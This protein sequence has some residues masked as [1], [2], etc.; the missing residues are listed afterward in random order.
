MSRKLT[1]RS[2]PDSLKKEA[3]RW[4]KALQAGDAM[5]RRRLLAV[6]P[7]A[8][9]EPGLRDVQLALA[10]EYG[11]PG[12]AVV[13]QALKDARRSHAERVELVLR[14]ADWAGDH[15]GG[16]RLLTRW[17]EIGRDSLHAAAATGNVAEVA[18]RLAADPA[19]A[20]RK[21]GPLD[22][23]PLLYLAYSRLPGSETRSVEIARLLLDHGAD[24]NARWIGPWGEPAFTALTG[25][26]GEGEGIQP[27]H[28]QAREL[29]AL[30]IERGAD[31]FDPQALYNTSITEDD[32]GWLEFLWTRSERQG[33]LDA[34][35]A[36]TGVLVAGNVLDY[37]LGNA[38]ANNHLRR[39]EWLLAHGADPNSLHA[40]SKRPQ[41]EEA[42][43]HG[44][45]VMATL[46]EG[47]GAERTTLEG[48]S[49]FQAACMS[50]DRPAARAIAADQP[51][52]LRDPKPMLAAA[53][54][55]RADVVSLLLELGVDVDV[56]DEIGQRG[57]QAAVA[58]GSLAVVELLVARG[59][60]I[61]RPT[62]S[63]GDGA[64]GYAAHFDRRE[65]AAFLAPLSRDVH[66]LTYLGFQARLAHLFDGDPGLVNARHRMGYTPLFALPPNEDDAMEMAA[67]LLDRGADPEIRDAAGGLTAEEGF[68][69]RGMIE[70]ADFL[71][72]R[73][74]RRSGPP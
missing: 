17:P 41:R 1:V 15:A 69:K 3:K 32:T 4:L 29:A 28:P 46:L 66:N 24:P 56:A 57:I 31:P 73:Q 30:L 58:G 20:N 42:L 34:W 18:R 47:A 6:T 22:R 68:R 51:D 21:G 43:I 37:L 67:F 59:A 13:S 64:M 44:H 49:A 61:D 60:D 48:L 19:A 65:I 74:A 8:P 53:R 50:L 23:E 25:P 70:L 5:A 2:T 54:G 62:T 35:R 33:R 12:W 52:C 40:Y 11:L 27:P 10:R 55:G 72:E 9:A 39:A 63:V 16:A 45:V 26:I 7:E 14:S 36:E 71:R 38:T